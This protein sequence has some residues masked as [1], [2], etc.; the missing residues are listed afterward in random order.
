[1]HRLRRAGVAGWGGALGAVCTLP[2]LGPTACLPHPLNA[3]SPHLSACCPCQ[4]RSPGSRPIAVHP[5]PPSAGRTQQGAAAPARGRPAAANSAIWFAN[6]QRGSEHT[7]VAGRSEAVF[8]WRQLTGPARPEQAA[9]DGRRRQA[10]R[11]Y[12]GKQHNA[13]RVEALPQTRCCLLHHASFLH[14]RARA[15]RSAEWLQSGHEGGGRWKAGA[16][17]D[18]STCTGCAVIPSTTSLRRDG[19]AAAVCVVSERPLV[20][21][22]P[23]PSICLPGSCDLG[24]VMI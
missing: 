11:G 24:S 4:R 2:P 22:S 19:R 18:D 15:G 9:P 21:H 12:A 5:S 6:M 13:S 8:L 20:G 17:T 7:Q 3:G 10:H 23:T 16:A 14:L 1:L